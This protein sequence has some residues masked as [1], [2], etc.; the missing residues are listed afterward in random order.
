MGDQLLSLEEARK[1]RLRVSKPTLYK[2]VLP[3]LATVRIGR[4][5]FVRESDLSAW[6]AA[7]AQVESR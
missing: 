2:E 5:R 1:Q 4:R 6:L 3:T 7:R